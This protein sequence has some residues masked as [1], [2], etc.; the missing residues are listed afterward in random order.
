VAK[1]LVDESLPRAVTHALR[2][3]GHDTED[4]RDVG[5]RGQSDLVVQQTAASGLRILVTG[6]LDFANPLRFPPGSHPGIVVLRVPTDLSP[7]LR[8]AQ[9]VDGIARAGGNLSGKLVI[10]EGARV[11]IFG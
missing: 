8:A 3:A 5:L 4:A 11:R 7:V 1:F 10:V 2:S 6:D 9:V